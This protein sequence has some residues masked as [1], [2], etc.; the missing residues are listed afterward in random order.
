[1][2]ELMERAVPGRASGL[3]TRAQITLVAVLV[4]LAAAAWAFTGDRMAGM[5]EGPGTDLGTIGFFVVGWIVMM[6]AMMFPST[7]PMAAI[8]QRVQ[9]ARGGPAG[10]TAIFVGGY[11][12]AW[13]AFGLAAWVVVEAVQAA[14]PGFPGASAAAGR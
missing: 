4:V 14:A 5:D 1:M 2:V 11:L 9:A 10:A 8:Y 13:T 6:A 3:A 12:L 7:W